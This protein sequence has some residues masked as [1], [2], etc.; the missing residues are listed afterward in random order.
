MKT[1]EVTEVTPVTGKNN[2]I[3]DKLVTFSDGTVLSVPIERN[4]RVGDQVTLS[5]KNSLKV[6]SK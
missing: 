4:Y 2:K 1:L 5:A 3:I 6:T